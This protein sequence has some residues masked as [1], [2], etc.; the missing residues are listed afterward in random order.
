MTKHTLFVCKSCSATI[1]HDDVED[2]TITEGVL[3]LRQLQ[4]LHSSELD[5][6]SVGCLWTCD[7]PCSITFVCPGKYTYHFVD[8]NYSQSV[9]EL[10]QFSELYINSADGYVKPPKMP[11]DLRSRLLVRIPPIEAT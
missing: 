9:S 6:Q 2:D 5:V 11:G 8:L 10:Q 4:E 7:R 3:L 1:A